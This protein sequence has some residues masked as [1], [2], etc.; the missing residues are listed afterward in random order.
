[1]G[2]QGFS[3]RVVTWS[4]ETFLDSLFAVF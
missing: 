2:L 3:R 1:L 4:T